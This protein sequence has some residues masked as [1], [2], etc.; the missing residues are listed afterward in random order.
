MAL[1]FVFVQTNKGPAECT[2]GTVLD[3]PLQANIW[4]KFYTKLCAYRDYIFK[5][6]LENIKV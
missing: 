4:Q 3:I 5:D 2:T 1:L 6:F